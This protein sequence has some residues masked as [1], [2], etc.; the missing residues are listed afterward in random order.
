MEAAIIF[1]QILQGVAY[2]HS[3]NIVHRDLKLENLM[4]DFRDDI[5]S[6]KI[7]DYG[8]SKVTQGVGDVL[9]TF[10]GSPQYVAP[11]ILQLDGP[12]AHYTFNVDAWSLGVIL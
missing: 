5:R 3:K 1:N 12:V 10:C 11:E 9:S 7:L 6:L 8:F 2:L 4:F